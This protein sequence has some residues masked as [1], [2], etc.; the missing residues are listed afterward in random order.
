MTTKNASIKQSPEMSLTERDSG[1]HLQLPAL[2]GDLCPPEELAGVLRRITELSG[3][4]HDQY[5][6]SDALRLAAANGHLEDASRLQ[7]AVLSG[8][9]EPANPTEVADA[10]RQALAAAQV[11]ERGLTDARRELWQEAL[12]TLAE[13][14]PLWRCHVLAGYPGA[15]ANLRVA[16][17]RLQEAAEDLTVR[18]GLLT[19]LDRGGLAISG[20]RGVIHLS[21]ALTRLSE[22]ID[23]EW[24]SWEAAGQSMTATVAAVEAVE[25]SA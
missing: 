3:L 10:T 8:E 6:A 16:F 12:S 24:G 19:M 7:R 4:L 5:R 23:V 18:L 20:D 1:L 25:V 22:V 17:R 2:A 11:R 15:L 9:A 13:V 14:E 21:E